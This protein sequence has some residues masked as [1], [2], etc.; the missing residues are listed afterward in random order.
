MNTQSP[1]I[2]DINAVIRSN[3]PAFLNQTGPSPTR[4]GPAMIGIAEGQ[5]VSVDAQLVPLGEGL[6]VTVDVSAELSGQCVRCLAPLHQPATIA[7]TQVFALS[8]DFITGDEA[9]SEEEEIPMVHGDSVDML[10]VVI[11]EAGVSLPFNPVCEDGCDDGDVPAPDGVVEEMEE[12]RVDPRWAGLEK[13][14]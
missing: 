14:L 2:F 8:E 11:D 4:I 9:A 7:A 13:F 5:E 1:F 12:Q 3:S 6:M 10:Q